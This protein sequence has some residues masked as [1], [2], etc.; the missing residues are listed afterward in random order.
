L[1]GAAASGA[2]LSGVAGVDSVGVAG[3]GVLPPQAVAARAAAIINEQK[4]CATRMAPDTN[5]L[6]QA[7]ARVSPRREKCALS[8]E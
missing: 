2:A 4:G 6:A 1:L 3:A 8:W 7:A 5:P